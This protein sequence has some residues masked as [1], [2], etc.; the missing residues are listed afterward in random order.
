MNL[1]VLLL[2]TSKV[3][4]NYSWNTKHPW[5]LLSRIYG[6]PLNVSLSLCFSFCQILFY[7]LTVSVLAILSLFLI[8]VNEFLFSEPA[9]I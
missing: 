2:I 5:N 6:N 3:W 1:A 7:Y 9:Y 8:L 4:R